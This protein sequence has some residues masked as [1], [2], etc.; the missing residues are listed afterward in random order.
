MSRILVVDDS[1]TQ[2]ERLREIL[3]DGGYAV[4][5]ARDGHEALSH[6]AQGEFDAVISDILM[7]EINGYDLCR[8]IK[9]DPRGGDTPVVLLST[10][11]NPMD[12]IMGLESGADN[13]ITKPYTP[14]HLLA[15][16][17]SVLEN[18][19]L[20]QTS[21]VQMGVE[22]VFLGKRF[23]IT[24]E[25]RQIIDLLVSTFEDIVRT[26]RIL[27]D[28]KAELAAAKAQVERH[29]LELEQRVAERTALLT[30]RQ[31]Q[32]SQAQAIA[33]C[34]NWRLELATGSPEWSE[35][36]YRIL[37]HSRDAPPL[38][39]ETWLT[40]IHPDD[41]AALEAEMREAVRQRRSFRSEYRFTPAMGGPLRHIL[42]EGDCELGPDGTTVALF[43]ICQDITERKVTE[44]ALR[45]ANATLSA[46]ITS[47]PLAIVSIDRDGLIGSWN[48]RAEEVFGHAAAE[49]TG[50]PAAG[51]FA[52]GEAE[53]RSLVV[54]AL[55]G[56]A[57]Q[58]VDVR[59]RHKDGRILD[60]EVSA[61]PLVIEGEIRGTVCAIQDVTA[62]RRMEQH[63]QQ[64]QK[65]EAVGQLTGGVAHDFNNLLAVI[66][67]NLDLV[68]E[69][70][71][72]EL[73]PS[74]A[75]PI[76]EAL[77]AALRGAE[78][79]RR[80][81]AFSRKQ[82][83]RPQAIDL[84]ALIQGTA[85]L[86]R[87]T[88]GG[89][90]EVRLD[91]AGDL[92]AAMA[93][94]SQVESAVTNLAINARD[95][96]PGG[97]T[98]SIETANATLDADAEGPGGD[99]VVVSVSDTGTGIAPELVQKIFEPFFTTKPVGKGTGLGLS[100]VYGFARQSG[101]QVKVYSELGHGTTFKL[102]LP[103][104]NASA[105]PSAQEGPAES[106]P[107][108]RGETVLVVEDDPDVRRIVVRQ[109]LDLGYRVLEAASGDEAL[110]AIAGGA[111]VD[112]LFTDVVMP[113]G[114]LGTEL[115]RRVRSLVP[116]LPVLFASGF[117]HASL[118]AG[119]NLHEIGEFLG[120]PYRKRDLAMKLNALLR[121]RSGVAAR[122]H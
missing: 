97:G 77:D 111:R 25:K 90:V 110:S 103:R 20:R 114:M 96:M 13:F 19:R 45:E 107:L 69:E 26:N 9:S 93:D 39:V 84:N 101:G 80:L 112:L 40:L 99:F 33:R 14:A 119:I 48:K 47:S 11:S 116:E 1:P 73:E 42:V 37:G 120:K 5:A 66:I 115:A 54:R 104:A 16:L 56:E 79:T 68:Q 18:R 38:P 51:L 22:L 113:G 62:R 32:L 15:R 50:R 53:G 31:R 63:L 78:L 71:G 121:S 30:E 118:V 109:V 35:E 67:G 85:T 117:A 23:T 74:L 94:A 100:M 70:A 55:S 98:L 59:A 29:A 105:L 10:L 57:V 3:E 34:G 46:L 106:E 92:W 122:V 36:M 6:F 82:P 75:E 43:G 83:L 60:L 2:L 21:R 58:G 12:I 86:L 17:S 4:A 87:R 61:A 24:S 76:Q 7:P 91:L 64:S 28:N 72:R 95:A 44:T 108:G 102:Y 65:M 81:L 41:R 88:L 49:M 8:R 89:A 27:Q 52:E